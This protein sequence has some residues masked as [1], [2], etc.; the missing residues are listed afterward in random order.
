M[1][2]KTKIRG[3]ATTP[4]EVLDQPD[5]VAAVLSP[6]R[7]TMLT[8]LREPHSASSLARALDLPRQKVNYHLRQLERLE[9]VS[10]VGRQQR[11]GL[12][13]RFFQVVAGRMLIDPQIL[14]EAERGAERRD[15]YAAEQLAAT[16]AGAVHDIGILMRAAAAESQRLATFT[17]ESELTFAGPDDLRRFVAELGALVARFDRP[18]ADGGRRHRFIAMS[19]PAI[20]QGADA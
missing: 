8:L 17:L 7:R 12:V 15:A 10:L 20:A 6:L 11:R 16:A 9:L 13:E 18:D 2:V 3:M 5:T 14:S 1:F 4:L 19:H